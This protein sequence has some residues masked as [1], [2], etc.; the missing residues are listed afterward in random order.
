MAWRGDLGVNDRPLAALLVGA[1]CL[2]KGLGHGIEVVEGK[3]ALGADR[4]TALL[5]PLGQGNE[6]RGRGELDIEVELLL[7]SRNLAKQ[8]VA[9]GDELDVYVDRSMRVESASSRMQPL[10]RS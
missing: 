2:G 3:L 8:L 10:A 5:P 7:E 4:G 6:V 9:I 1:L